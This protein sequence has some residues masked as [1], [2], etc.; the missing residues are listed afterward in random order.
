MT[1]PIV[2]WRNADNTDFVTSWNIGVVKAGETSDEFALQIWNNRGGEADVS[3]MQETQLTIK[4]ENGGDTG[5]VVTEKWIE[6][7][8]DTAT[9]PA[10]IAIGGQTSVNVNAK[11]NAVGIIK[12]TANSGDMATDTNNYAKITLRAKPPLNATAGV[13]NFKV[14]V[15]Y[16]YT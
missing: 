2:E 12:G 6:A 7:R 9:S 16:Y 8:V 1:A 11:N 4:D 14:R 5:S 15:F 13:R 10:F 3:D